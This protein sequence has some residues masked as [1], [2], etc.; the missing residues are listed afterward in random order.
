MR[1]TLFIMTHLGSE[2]GLLKDTLEQNPK[3]HVFQTGIEYKHHEDLKELWDH[4]HRNNNA[5]AWWADVILTN[6]DFACK[7]LAKYCKFLYF[8]SKPDCLPNI[9]LDHDCAAAHYR[10]RLRG[11]VQWY[12]RSGG[13]WLREE[14]LYEED[15]LRISVESI[16]P[17][18]SFD[19]QL[20]CK[21]KS[22]DIADNFPVELVNE[23]ALSYMKYD[24]F[25]SG[26]PNPA[27]G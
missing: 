12:T 18:L 16:S 7:E 26:I 19:Y 8:V 1:K 11:L 25:I 27:N 4:S 6:K 23:C 5:A 17:S 24:G 9:K 20:S 10:Y 21:E 14:D 3:I 22:F 13:M 15:R 2:W